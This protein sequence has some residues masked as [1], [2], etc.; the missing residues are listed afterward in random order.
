MRCV[1]CHGRG[2]GT[3]ASR[4]RARRRGRP[5]SPRSSRARTSTRRGGWWCPAI[6][7]P[8]GCSCIRWRATA[9]GDPFHGGG[10]HWAS[11]DAPEWQTLAAWVRAGRPATTTTAALDFEAYRTRIEP[12]FLK[13]RDGPAGKVTC[14]GCHS[15]IATRLK[16]RHRRRPGAAWTAEQSRQNFAAA[17]PL[18]VGGDPLKSRLL[19]PRR[20]IPR[21]AAT[22]ATAAASSGRP[23]TIRSGRRWPDGSAPL[24][25]R[26]RP[27]AP[28]PAP[29]GPLTTRCSRRA[30]SRSSAPSA[31]G[32]VRCTQC[33]TRG[34]GSGFALQPIADGATDWTDEQA[35]KN[36][37][38]VSRWSLPAT[39][40]PAG[41]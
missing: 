14:A 33:H 40:L 9:G 16:L 23:R 35:R 41:C 21:R 19:R 32:L 4:F 27:A 29:P 22:R 37:A 6:P 38:S 28:V 13:E 26:P 36:F 12:I 15:G 11:K 5:S 10:K 18:M 3:A 39:R 24:R 8:A 7:T 31:T 25:R 2:G 17:S 1:Q 30:S 20:S 34:T